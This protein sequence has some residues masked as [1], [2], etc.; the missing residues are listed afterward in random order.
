MR[1]LNS[2]GNTLQVLNEAKKDL[3]EIPEDGYTTP[4]EEDLCLKIPT[5]SCTIFSRVHATLQPAL[6]VSRLV[7]WL[8]GRSV[9]LYFF[10]DFIF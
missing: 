2:E 7:G 4:C 3:N 6:S 8:V 10:Y 1:R 9:T 5:K